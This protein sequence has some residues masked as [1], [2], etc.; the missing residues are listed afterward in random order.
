MGSELLRAVEGHPREKCCRLV[1]AP[2][3]YARMGYEQIA[4]INDYPVGHADIFY[5]KR[6]D[7]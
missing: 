7:T 6:L 1:Q 2:G 4:G 5:A 3:F